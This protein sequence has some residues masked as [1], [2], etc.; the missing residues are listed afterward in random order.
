MRSGKNLLAV[1]GNFALAMLIAG[2][3]AAAQ[4]EEVLY[5]FN[6]LSGD[7]YLPQ[8]SLIFDASGNLYGTTTFGG[9]LSLCGGSGCGTVFEMTK[10]GGVWTASVLHSFNGGTDGA[11]PYAGLTFDASGNFYGT[12]QYG[13]SGTCSGGAG[14][15]GTVFELSPKAGGGWAEKI[16]HTFNHNGRDGYGPLGG[17]I[18]DASGNLYGTTFYG[19]AGSFGTVFELS[20]AAGGYW[21]E[22]ILHGFNNDDGDGLWPSAGLIFDAS[23]DLYGTTY[24]GGRYGWGTAFRLAPAAGGKRT[25]SIL[26]SFND[27]G[28]DGAGPFAS[29]IFD[30]SGN[31]YSST[32]YGGTDVCSDT[33]GCGTVFEL[34]P[35]AAG[36]WT[37]KILK[38]FTTYP[39]AGV[40]VDASGNLY[41]TTFEGGTGPCSDGVIVGCGTVFELSPQGGGWTEKILHSFGVVEGDGAYTFAGLIFDS[42]GDLY[43]TTWSG[44][45]Y[46]YGSVFEVTP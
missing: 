26:H 11:E 2:T 37:E 12:T 35:N 8:S 39:Y 19:G 7:G 21:T 5:S 3:S 36:G 9:N 1:L 38:S 29:L 18:L 46:N 17:L 28:S 43:G 22:T 20:P 33:N 44:G 27:N 41:G 4:T 42:S 24:G 14:G 10:V 25:E 31:L 13:G 32:L 34:S 6:D 30:E 45:A 40:I 15:C 23:G 16:L